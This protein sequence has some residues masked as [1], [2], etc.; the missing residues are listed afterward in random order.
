M[1][2]PYD[3]TIDYG[4]QCMKFAK[5]HKIW[6]VSSQYDK[7]MYHIYQMINSSPRDNEWKN[8]AFYAWYEW[9]V[10]TENKI[11]SDALRLRDSTQVLDKYSFIT[12][13]LDDKLNPTYN[14]MLKI[15]GEVMKLKGGS[16]VHKAYY[17]LEKHRTD[18]N[19][20]PYIHHH[21][22]FLIIVNKDI[23]KS[24]I[25]ELLRKKTTIKK[26]CTEDQYVDVKLPNAKQFSRRA[27][28]FPV[29]M[30][31]VRGDKCESKRK[32]IDLDRDWRDTCG[33]PHLIEYVAT[34][35]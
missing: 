8:R 13:G 11:S 27:Q 32:C 30:S 25:V 4:L 7:D 12:I 31:Y 17:V 34:Q 16:Y 21:I 29:C 20:K 3:P 22:H 2:K 35:E 10:H 28:P 33:V 18:A 9:D 26:F 23:R 19:G 6:H 1:K 14:D 5:E 24:K 15:A